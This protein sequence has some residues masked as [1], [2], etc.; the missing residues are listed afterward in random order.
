[1]SAPVPMKEGN[2]TANHF[3]RRAKD[4]PFILFSLSLSLFPI[5]E[6]YSLRVCQPHGTGR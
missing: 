5:S 1:M 4:P 2:Q 6:S 3:H